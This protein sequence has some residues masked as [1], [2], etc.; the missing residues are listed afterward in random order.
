MASA[1]Q[2]LDDELEV[3]NSLL[4]ENPKRAFKAA[5]KLALEALKAKRMGHVAK[6]EQ[7]RLKA[8]SKLHRRMPHLLEGVPAAL[9]LTFTG[10]L[11]VWFGGTRG[12][13]VYGAPTLL[14]G[15][16]LALLF[17][18][19]LGH[20]FAAKMYGIRVHGVYLAGRIGLEPTLLINLES[21][22]HAKP[23]ERFWFHMAGPIATF[24]ASVLLAAS[25]WIDHYPQPLKIA[26]AALPIAVFLTEVLYSRVHGDVARALRALKGGVST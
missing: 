21:Y 10:F 23:K 14:A 6:L 20:L 5:S 8:F 9:L 26:A 18:H 2:R 1:G 17:S 7:I 4:E 13:Y 11:L 22:Y 16:A 24:A 3:L 19:P 25:A 12:E 15:G